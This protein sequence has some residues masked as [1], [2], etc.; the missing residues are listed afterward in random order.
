MGDEIRNP[1]VAQVA[2]RHAGAGW[3]NVV[4][5]LGGTNATNPLTSKIGLATP[6]TGRRRLRSLAFSNAWVG[7]TQEPKCL[8]CGTECLGVTDHGEHFGICPWSRASFSL[9]LAI[10]KLEVP[11]MPNTT[12]EG[13]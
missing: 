11:G 13:I 6:A 5:S 4:R 2:D 3:G 10:Q 9:F 12:P 7:R 1:V 8:R